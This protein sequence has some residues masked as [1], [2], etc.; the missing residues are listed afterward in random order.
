MLDFTFLEWWNS[1]PTL[2]TLKDTKKYFFNNLIFQKHNYT[3]FST[4]YSMLGNQLSRP[5]LE[6]SGQYLK[7]NH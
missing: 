3:K 5:V 6:D 4:F 7:E 1:I 2:E